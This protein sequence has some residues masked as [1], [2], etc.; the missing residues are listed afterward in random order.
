MFVGTEIR[1]LVVEHLNGVENIMNLEMNASEA[2]D[3]LKWTIQAKEDD[4][5]KV[6]IKILIGLVSSYLRLMSLRSLIYSESL[7]TRF[8]RDQ[9]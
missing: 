8:F 1:D 4:D 5:G 9:A 7:R 6:R 2:Y 3:D